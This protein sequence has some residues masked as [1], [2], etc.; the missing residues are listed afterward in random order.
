MSPPSRKPTGPPLDP[1]DELAGRKWSA[2]PP[3]TVTSSTADPQAEAR[4]VLADV[5]VSLATALDLTDILNKIVDGIIRVTGCE[6]GFLML[7][8]SDGD[9]STFT[10][11]YADQREWSETSARAISRSVRNRVVE[12]RELFTSSDLSQL[13]EFRSNESIQTGG[14]FAAVCLPLLHRESLIGVIYADSAHMIPH[15]LAESQQ[16]LRAFGQQASFAIESSRSRG[17]PVTRTDRDPGRRSARTTE[18]RMGK[19]VSRDPAMESVFSTMEKVA[20]LPL[21]VLIEGETGTGKDVLAQA[22]HD[23]SPRANKRFVAVNAGG[24]HEELV[25]SILFGHKKGSFTSAIAD[26]PGLFDLAE[27]GTLFLDE[28]GDMPL[29]IQPKLLRVLENREM[30]RLGE[31]GVVRKVDVRIIAATNRDL[32]AL[33]SAGLFRRDLFER[34]HVVRV[35]LPPLR[36]RREDIV[37]LANHFLAAYAAEYGIPTPELSRDARAR[38]VAD[39][40]EGNVRGLRNAIELSIAFRDERN[41]IHADA[42]ERYFQGPAAAPKPLEGARSLKEEMERH[43][44]EVVRRALADNL[45]NV[46]KAATALGISRQQLHAKINKYGIVTRDD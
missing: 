1:L 20:P 38:I 19:L 41:I 11:R 13:E 36:D 15:S 22:I 10:G 18:F 44:A 27:G 40:W 43:E 17:E 42:I 6:R 16:V 30:S 23:N 21:T 28:I 3:K 35:H 7:R 5:V 4:G 32:T 14:I 46:S 37:P 2:T 39:P 31:E 9:F 34:L 33:V 45:N 25:S 12:T 29:P 8:E 26:R 24:M